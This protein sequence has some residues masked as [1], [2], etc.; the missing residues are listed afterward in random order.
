MAECTGW[1]LRKLEGSQTLEIG[2]GKFGMNLNLRGLKKGEC[3]ANRLAR[4]PRIFAF[5]LAKVDADRLEVLRLLLELVW[6]A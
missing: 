1:N 4:N 2:T 6:F 5:L 3:Y